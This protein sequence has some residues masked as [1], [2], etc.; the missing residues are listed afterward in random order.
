LSQVGGK[1]QVSRVGSAQAGLPLA[2]QE[3]VAYQPR[4]PIRPFRSDDAPALARIF[5]GAVH[6]IAAHHY[7]PEQIAAW[8]P[9]VPSAER[10]LGW[11]LDG[12]L[13]LVAVDAADAPIAF[14]DLEADGHVDHLFC[15]P[16]VA[17][18]GVTASLYAALEAAARQCRIARLYTEASEPARRFFERQGFLMLHRRN[19]ELGGV[20][21]HNYAM[22]KRLDGRR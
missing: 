21:I 2:K 4:M 5:H 12:R 17:G 19:F 1:A 16:H 11:A 8:A 13:L 14:A 18:T 3:F 6:E 10:L 15:S 22:E 9:E 20:P 7:S